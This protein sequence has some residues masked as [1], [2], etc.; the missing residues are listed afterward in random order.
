MLTLE[1]RTSTASYSRSRTG[2]SIL[3][4]WL[5]TNWSASDTDLEGD[6]Y[7]C[8]RFVVVSGLQDDQVISVDVV[9]QSVRFIDSTKPCPGEVLAESL[10]SGDAFEWT[11]NG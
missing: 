3:S 9:H 1:Q 2:P 10:G 6:H 11:S 5:R 8:L 4:A 7:R